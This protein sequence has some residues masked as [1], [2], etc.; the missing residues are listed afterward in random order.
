MNTHSRR[1]FIQVAAVGGVASLAITQ[2][3]CGPSLDTEIG[4]I[5]T[6]IPLLKPFLPNQAVLLDKIA[7]ITSDLQKAYRAG[8][9]TNAKTFFN[10]LDVN[11][12]TLI[13]DVGGASPRIIFL[14][15]IVG[16]ALRAVAA[17]INQST[18]PAIMSAMASPGEVERVRV[19]GSAESA[20]KLLG[21]LK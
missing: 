5:L 11:I 6:T 15:A 7:K 16:V 21:S 9:F 3:S 8:D 20:A 10:D 14:V 12:Q 17:L 1:K 2:L 19:L 18:P 4:I 13:A